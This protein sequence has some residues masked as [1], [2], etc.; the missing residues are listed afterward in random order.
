MVSGCGL[1]EIGNSGVV[2]G[3]F[4]AELALFLLILRSGGDTTSKVYAESH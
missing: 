3:D 2:S 1:S 4:V